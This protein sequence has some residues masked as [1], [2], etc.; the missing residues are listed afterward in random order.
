MSEYREGIDMRNLP[1]PTEPLN[2]KQLLKGKVASADRVPL[3]VR[4]FTPYYNTALKQASPGSRAPFN[5]RTAA[6]VAEVLNLK[7][8]IQ[9]WILDA[10]LYL[11]AL[12]QQLLRNKEHLLKVLM[13]I[14]TLHITATQ[15]PLPMSKDFLSRRV[16]CMYLQRIK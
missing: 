3:L 6:C 9:G 7:Y 15:L 10:S 1:E 11:S 16:C 5:K 8:V 4:K 13:F 14:I 2:W 12:E